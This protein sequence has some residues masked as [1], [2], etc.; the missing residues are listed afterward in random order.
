MD[1]LCFSTTGWDE[2]WGSRQHI[3]QRLASRGHRVLFIERQLGPE[4]LFARRGY[5]HNLLAMLMP[6]PP[7]LV[8]PTLWRWQPPLVLPGRYYSSLL[9]RLGQ[10][11]LATQVRPL[12][13][14]LDFHAP[15]LWLYPPH[16]S[17]LVGQLGESLVVYHCIERFSGEQHGRK[18][19]VMESQEA[20][21]LGIADLVFTHSKGLLE[22][23]SP[24]TRRPIRLIPSAADVAHFQSTREI[25][26]VMAAIP[27]PRLVLSGTLDERIDWSLLESIASQKAWQLC[28][29]GKIRMKFPL[30]KIL[31]GQENVHFLGYHA[32]QDLPTLLNG[33]D[34][35]LL[36]YRLTGMTRYINPLKA[37]EYL[38]VGK[39]IVSTALPELIPLAEWVDMVEKGEDSPQTYHRRF[40]QE[41][42]HCLETETP[43]KTLAR[44]DSARQHDW[45]QRVE[46]ML[47]DMEARLKE[48]HAA[49]G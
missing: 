43:A 4:H 46:R 42:E 3:M 26:P 38:A 35:F 33:A 28:L 39:P 6:P 24:L 41:I 36:P 18:R 32:Y 2:I 8:L 40:I 21:L 11:Y 29:V 9:N 16:S 49:Q 44:R 23:Y 30:L 20:E 13:R 10:R 25:H 48:K 14:T 17:S 34:L 1:I 37:Y 27:S 5:F 22:L 15:V 31:S 7:R 19:G 47:E 12:L 45:D